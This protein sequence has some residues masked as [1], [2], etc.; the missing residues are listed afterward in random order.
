MLDPFRQFA[1][2]YGFW[3]LA[4]IHFF[5]VIVISF[6]DLDFFA[7][8]TPLNL[9]LSAILVLLASQADDY[10]KM[11]HFLLASF[12]IG[13]GVEVLGTQ[14]GFPFGD[15]RYLHN[16]GF[17]LIEVPIVIG[18]N[19]FLLAYSTALWAK[20]WTINPLLRMI[21]AAA[22]MVGLD[23]FIEPLSAQL[24]FWAWA[25]NVIPWENYLAW[26]VVAFAIQ[27]IFVKLNLQ[28]DTK[29]ARW[30]LPL[31]AFFFIMLNIFL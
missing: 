3:I 24:G 10:P 21:I 12:T 2:S 19:W 27:F 4:V 9:Y 13:F 23:F 28:H 25:G 29:L 7:A 30:Y 31:I 11:L 16:L 14:T 17:K 5:G 18:L 15:Y 26:F 6:A 22:L 8:F 1:R 20:R